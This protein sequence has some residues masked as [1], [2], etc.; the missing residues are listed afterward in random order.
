PVQPRERDG[1]AQGIDGGESVAL[2]IDGGAGERRPELDLVVPD[3]QDVVVAV[4]VGAGD[5]AR[6]VGGRRACRHREGG[7]TAVEAV[8]HDVA[9]LEWE[10]AD[11][12][13][14]GGRVD[15]GDQI[16]QGRAVL[17][18]D[19]GDPQGPG[20]VEGDAAAE[21]GVHGRLDV[22]RGVGGAAVGDDGTS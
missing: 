20:G 14:V 6:Q 19:G 8:G 17:A 1:V 18:V 13:G 11:L 12:D 10:V 7:G 21:V 15:Q 22:G 3:D 16:V 5:V 2:G 4:G 9:R